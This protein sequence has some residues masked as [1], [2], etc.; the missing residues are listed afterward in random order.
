MVWYWLGSLLYFHKE[1]FC[2]MKWQQNQIEFQVTFLGSTELNQMCLMPVIMVYHLEYTVFRYVVCVRVCV[3]VCVCVVCYV[4][5]FCLLQVRAV[6]SV[7]PGEYSD[8]YPFA[9]L[10]MFPYPP[11][12]VLY[13]HCLLSQITVVGL[14]VKHLQNI[15]KTTYTCIFSSFIS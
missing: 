7:G 2:I 11:S 4:L 3:C 15:C 9:S 14:F 10:G 8:C 13:T 12:L 5:F 1:Q 6:T